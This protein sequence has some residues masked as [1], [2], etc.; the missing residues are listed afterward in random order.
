MPHFCFLSRCL[1]CHHGLESSSLPKTKTWALFLQ[2]FLNDRSPPPQ[3]LKNLL[4]PCCPI[5]VEINSSS[6]F[7][8]SST[9]SAVRHLSPSALKQRNQ[10][11]YLWG[12]RIHVG[13]DGSCVHLL[14]FVLSGLYATHSCIQNLTNRQ[15]NAHK[16]LIREIHIF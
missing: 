11:L 1:C 12:S 14:A 3:Q 4:L 5:P 16:S 15:Q 9:A 8:L 6:D 2:T 7:T 10:G 13:E